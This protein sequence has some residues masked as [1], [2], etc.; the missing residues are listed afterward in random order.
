MTMRDVTVRPDLRVAVGAFL[1]RNFLHGDIEGPLEEVP[2]EA[3]LGAMVG[4]LNHGVAVGLTVGLISQAGALY[5]GD[6]DPRLPRRF[7]P[8]RGVCSPG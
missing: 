2:L 8:G 7:P 6:A 5:L 4:F 1:S 3:A